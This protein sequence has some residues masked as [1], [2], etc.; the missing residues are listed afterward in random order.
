MGY[1]IKK[2]YLDDEVISYIDAA[3]SNA[4]AGAQSYTDAQ[5]STEA[6]ARA[7]A[8]AVK[9][10]TSACDLMDR[11]LLSI[12]RETDASYA[13]LIPST[14]EAMLLIETMG[15]RTW[16]VRERLRAVVQRIHSEQRMAFD[17]RI[18]ATQDELEWYWRLTNQVVARLYSL[19]GESRPLP[20][21]EDFAVPP[22]TLPDFIGRLQNVLKNHHVT[23]TLFGHAGHGQLH[24][25][26][27][28][29]VRSASDLRRMSDLALELYQE[30]LAV[31]GTISG[32]HGIGLV[33]QEYMPIV[34]DPVTL[35][36]QREIKKLFDPNLILNPGKIEIPALFQRTVVTS[37]VVSASKASEMSR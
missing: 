26:P 11:R 7:A 14:A 2:K 22:E 6:A 15:D 4:Q 16:E 31:G 32:E 29:D 23:A 20:F 36:L 34:F 18:A 17:F 28:L 21:V 19:R 24:V 37:A 1:Q 9:M 13:R 27:F 33:Q 12:A 10:G 30:V 5:I 35:Q 3:G 8:E 25:R